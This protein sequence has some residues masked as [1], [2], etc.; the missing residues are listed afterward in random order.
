MPG[1][2]EEL[3]DI[4]QGL[5]AEGRARDPHPIAGFIQRSP[6]QD[7]NPEAVALSPKSRIQLQ[8]SSQPTLFL[9]RQLELRCGLNASQ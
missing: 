8:K 4:R 7:P 5:F 9:H 6:E 3:V 2:L 1:H